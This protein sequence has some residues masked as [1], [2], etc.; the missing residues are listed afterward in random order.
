MNKYHYCKAEDFKTVLQENMCCIQIGENS[1]VGYYDTYGTEYFYLI[2]GE[3]PEKLLTI[4]CKEVS[5]LEE[6]NMLLN[7]TDSQ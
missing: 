5:S 1:H 3:K 7:E 4:G 2:I 6:Y